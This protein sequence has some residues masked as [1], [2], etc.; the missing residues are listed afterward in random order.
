MV[1]D[2]VFEQAVFVA[3]SVNDFGFNNAVHHQ[4]VPGGYP[5]Q[6]G[7]HA[8]RHVGVWAH[9]GNHRLGPCR[10]VAP[11][12]VGLGAMAQQQAIRSS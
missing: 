3:E 10:Q 7:V 12:R 8:G 1:S 9:E 4:V 11:M 6:V 2:Q 5:G